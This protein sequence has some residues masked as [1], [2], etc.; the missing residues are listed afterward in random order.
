LGYKI[1]IAVAEQE[2][3]KNGFT[4][5]CGFDFKGCSLR[6][7]PKSPKLIQ[8]LGRISSCQGVA[9]VATS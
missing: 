7:A 9:T 8:I 5:A 4:N 6:D 2:G 1:T 3:A